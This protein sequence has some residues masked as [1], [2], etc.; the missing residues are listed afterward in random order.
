MWRTHKILD[1]E[2]KHLRDP[3]KFVTYK[4]VT[5][6]CKHVQL[7]FE[8]HFWFIVPLHSVVHI[9]FTAGVFEFQK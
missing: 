5:N 2:G 6:E 9:E 1:V 3:S 4:N 7:K 8:L